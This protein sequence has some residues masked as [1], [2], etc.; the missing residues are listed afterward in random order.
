M[1]SDVI[2]GRARTD[3]PRFTIWGRL[4]SSYQDWRRERDIDQITDVLSQLS[5]RQLKLLG[6]CRTSLPLHVE[7]AVERHYLSA[8]QPAL[9]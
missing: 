7:R 1:Y 3:K 2:D 8:G 6:A 4:R 5:D 9:A